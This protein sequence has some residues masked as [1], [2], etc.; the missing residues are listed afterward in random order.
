MAGCSGPCVGARSARGVEK[1]EED[2]LPSQ[3]PAHLTARN[4]SEERRERDV[5]RWIA[6]RTLARLAE[7]RLLQG[8]V[9]RRRNVVQGL[10]AEEK[11]C[12]QV[13]LR[14][15]A[16]V[17]LATTGGGCGAVSSVSHI[18]FTKCYEQ[19]E[20]RGTDYVFD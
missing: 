18:Y 11:G 14:K 5:S 8:K 15:G 16:R 20:G 1:R 7:E 3:L 12:R 9:N 17:W 10:R 2:S 4:T 6:K 19:S 13:G